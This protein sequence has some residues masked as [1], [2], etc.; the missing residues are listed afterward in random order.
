MKAAALYNLGRAQEASGRSSEARDAYAESLRLRPSKAVAARLADLG[1]SAPAPADAPVCSTPMDRA[2]V[3]DCLMKSV[4]EDDA[5]RECTLAPTSLPNFE[6]ATYATSGVG[7]QNVVVVARDTAGWAVVAELAS[8][9][10]PGMMGIHEDLGAVTIDERPLG[11][12]TVVEVTASKTRVDRDM[13][14]DEIETEETDHLVVCVVGDATTPTRCPL[15]VVTRHLYERDRMGLAEDGE[16]LDAGLTT[17][18]LPIRAEQRISVELGEDGV[19]KLRVDAGK[20]D[21]DQL[22]D[23]PLW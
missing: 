5:P 10:N 7:E 13:G 23:R 4:P 17:P 1:K 16:G 12:H 22:G 3:C 11:G 14:I 9:Y 8:V 21:A 15:D 19:A 20:V 18:G 2:L 6:I